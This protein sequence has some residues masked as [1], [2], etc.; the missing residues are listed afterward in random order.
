[1]TYRT[2]TSVTVMT[3]HDLKRSFQQLQTVL[4]PQLQKET[5]L[6]LTGR[7]YT[8]RKRQELNSSLPSPRWKKLG[9]IPFRRTAM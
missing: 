9:L 4:R 2:V 7:A 5:E 1:M 8:S 3:F 6:L